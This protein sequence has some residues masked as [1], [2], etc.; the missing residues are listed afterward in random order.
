LGKFRGGDKHRLIP[1]SQP[2]VPQ[3][4]ILGSSQSSLRDCVMEWKGMAQGLKLIWSRGI[5]GTTKVVP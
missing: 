2:N 3:D 5:C 1:H 4:C